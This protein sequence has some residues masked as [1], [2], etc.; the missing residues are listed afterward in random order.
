MPRNIYLDLDGVFVDFFAAASSILGA[1]YRSMPARQ[2]WGVLDRVPRLFRG[3]APLPGA[4][5][6]WDGVQE[7]AAASGS[8]VAVLS[9][10]PWP[11]HQLI[12]AAEDKRA[13]V[14]EHLCERTPVIL[15]CGGEAKTLC[16]AP[17]DVL[18]DDLGRNI[19]A[20]RQHGGVGIL[21]TDV[22]STLRELAQALAGQGT[23]A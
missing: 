22:E 11:T 20:W 6:L 8:R 13:W 18:I 1:D 7:A 10:L 15:V 5:R 3:I 21:H 9:A 19:Q 2:A 12:T 16:A 23:S 17:G 4:R 14:R